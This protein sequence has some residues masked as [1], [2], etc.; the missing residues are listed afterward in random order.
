MTTKHLG[1]RWTHGHRVLHQENTYKDNQDMT[2]NNDS[3]CLA[4]LGDNLPADE[5]HL[6]PHNILIH[7]RVMPTTAKSWITQFH[8]QKLT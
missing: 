2:G 7:G 3:D 8:P 1:V 4:N 5:P 6:Q